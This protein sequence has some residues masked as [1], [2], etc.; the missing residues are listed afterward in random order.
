VLEFLGQA[1]LEVAAWFLPRLVSPWVLSVLAI[2]GALI[3]YEFAL[4]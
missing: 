4:T 1:L 2:V 3:V